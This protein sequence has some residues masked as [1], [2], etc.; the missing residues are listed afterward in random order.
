MITIWLALMFFLDFILYMIFFD[1]ILSWLTL[2]WLNFRPKFLS[3]IIDPIYNFINK[4]IP[5]TF[6]PFRFDALIAIIFIYIFEYLLITFIPWL[7]LEL[8]KIT[9]SF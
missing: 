5:T 6:W 8:Y 1:V 9:H 2:F 3:L 4:I 7:S